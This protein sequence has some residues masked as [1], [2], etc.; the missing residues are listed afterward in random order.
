MAALGVAERGLRGAS[1]LRGR[2]FAA[3]AGALLPLPEEELEEEP[4]E[5]DVFEE[6]PFEELSFEE[7]PDDEPPD[8]DPLESDDDV[9]FEDEP[10]S[11]LPA[12]SDDVE[13]P[14]ESVR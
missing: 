5:D 1:V 14:R 10:A 8:D 7:P 3:G 6:L 11:L 2:Q 9:L 13:V 4:P 12:P